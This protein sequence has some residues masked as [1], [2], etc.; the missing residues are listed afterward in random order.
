[1]KSLTWCEGRDYA[2]AAFVRGATA[3]DVRIRVEAE[4][5]KLRKGVDG[6]LPR[7]VV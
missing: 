5:N 2:D 1:M 6:Q 4:V 7:A 3:F